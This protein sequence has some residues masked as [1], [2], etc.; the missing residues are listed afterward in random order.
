M[1]SRRSAFVDMVFLSDG[2]HETVIV[3]R[4]AGDGNRHARPR[5]SL[6]FCRTPFSSR[7]GG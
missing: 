7:H 6:E 5:C 3:I 1:R 4:A 2:S